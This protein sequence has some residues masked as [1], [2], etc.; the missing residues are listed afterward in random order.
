VIFGSKTN[1][2]AAL[3]RIM[4]E[5]LQFAAKLS[6]FKLKFFSPELGMID[7][8]VRVITP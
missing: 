4:K 7:A 2:L 3:V 1:H 8:R 6:I 5:K